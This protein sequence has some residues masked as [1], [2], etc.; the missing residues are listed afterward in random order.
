[1]KKSKKTKARLIKVSIF[2]VGFI[3]IALVVCISLVSHISYAEQPDPGT[4]LPDPSPAGDQTVI[5]LIAP[6]PPVS[7][8]APVNA[9]D[10]SDVQNVNDESTQG[11]A[12]VPAEPASPDQTATGND[13]P[14][15][16]PATTDQSAPQ[17]DASTATPTQSDADPGQTVNTTPTAPADRDTNA[18][19]APVAND[20]QIVIE[21]P[22][23]PPVPS[24]VLTT[25]P[26]P[27]VSLETIAPKKYFSFDLAG[28]PIATER[29]L[30][31]FPDKFKIGAAGS[32]AD[33]NIAINN[34]DPAKMI[35]SGACSKTFFVVLGYAKSDDYD[36]DPAKFVYN[37]AFSCKNG[38]YYYE[39]SDLPKDLADGVYYFLVA[40]EGL[41]GPWQPITAI[42]PI[43]ITSA[44]K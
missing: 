1:M 2:A 3:G 23:A 43:K 28:D 29:D 42:Q 7:S 22:V 6:T 18:P 16:A 30:S 24:I 25:P 31:W 19:A 26:A 27:V 34:D 8:D 38:G 9:P 11:E 5:D 36:K 12:A 21:K 13:A 39:L 15:P 41:T 17:A 40:E 14:T 4:T 35:F 37:K 44:Y 20:D 10:Q 32:N 33:I